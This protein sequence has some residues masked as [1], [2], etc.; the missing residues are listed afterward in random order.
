MKAIRYSSL[1][2]LLA[3]SLMGCY[4][5]ESHTIAIEKEYPIKPNTEFSTERF[6]LLS[7]NQKGW[8]VTFY[9]GST[10]QFNTKRKDSSASIF[11][12]PLADTPRAFKKNQQ[13][14]EEGLIQTIT[15]RVN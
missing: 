8:W 2:L 1:I 6:S 3:V 7:P 10:F 14:Y 4:L 11:I 9:E 5:Y 12:T 15:A 13:E